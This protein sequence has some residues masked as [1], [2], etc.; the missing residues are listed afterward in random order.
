[1]NEESRSLE[2]RGWIKEN[3]LNV[4]KREEET[5]VVEIRDHR[6]HH[7]QAMIQN[8]VMMDQ[9]TV[10]AEATDKVPH[11]DQNDQSPSTHK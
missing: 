1:M 4:T 2:L 8:Q 3:D 5:K 9:T 11:G 6:D 7:H 10:M